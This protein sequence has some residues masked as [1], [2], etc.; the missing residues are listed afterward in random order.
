[1]YIFQKILYKTGFSAEAAVIHLSI[2]IKIFRFHRNRHLRIFPKLQTLWKIIN[3]FGPLP[4]LKFPTQTFKGGQGGS[5]L[6]TTL[7]ATDLNFFRTFPRERDPKYPRKRPAAISWQLCS[8]PINKPK[9]EIGKGRLFWDVIF[10]FFFFLEINMCRNFV[11]P[12]R[13]HL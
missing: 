1:M 12:L 6:T 10:F 5:A 3:P 9:F 13:T 11:E 4:V 7:S 8:L 2:S